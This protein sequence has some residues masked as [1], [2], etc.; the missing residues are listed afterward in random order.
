MNS[1]KELERL[2]KKKMSLEKE[3]SLLEDKKRIIANEIRKMA[4][5]DSN[6]KRN[7]R[8]KRLFR[9]GG[10]VEM[11]LGECIDEDFLVGCLLS[12]KNIEVDS[13]KWLRIK[14]QGE[15]YF[16]IKENKKGGI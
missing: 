8:S 4:H 14:V 13:E 12:I 6:E 1:K 5:F 11:I 7:E 15:R 9:L 2:V 3:Y 10:M 16:E